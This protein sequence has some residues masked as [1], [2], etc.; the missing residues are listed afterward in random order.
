MIPAGLAMP[1]LGSISVTPPTS[2]GLTPTYYSYGY[3]D[4]FDFEEWFGY[5]V[6][7]FGS[8]DIGVINP[9]P[10]LFNGVRLKALYNNQVGLRETSANI[11]FFGSVVPNWSEV[12]INGVKYLRSSFYNWD[13]NC[14]TLNNVY[15]PLQDG[16][17]ATVIFK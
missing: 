9:N 7:I 17:V 11:Q 10:F 5:G 1:Y 12:T 13:V 3:P 8:V 2:F 6:D 4:D 16:Q 15:F 14:W